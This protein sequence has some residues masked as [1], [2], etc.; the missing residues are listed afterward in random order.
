MSKRIVITGATGLIGKKLV[1]TLSKRENEIIIFTRNLNK[2]RSIFPRLETFVEWDYEKPELWQLYLE[3][4]DA[5][6]HLAGISLL[7]KR[8]NNHFKD[9]ALKSR[10]LSTKNLIEAI[11]LGKSQP[12][13]FI[14]ASAIGFYGNRKDELLTENS[15]AGNDFLANVCKVWETESEKVTD[16]G[17]RNVRVR[18]GIVLTPDDG[19]LKQML[20]P[21][22]LFIGGPLGNGNQWMSWLHIDDIINIYLYALDNKEIYGAINAVSP[23]PIRMKEFAKTLGKILKRPAIFP[24]PQCILRLVVGEAA[25]VVTASQ[26]V[27][28]N[29]LLRSGY[30][31]KFNYLSEAFDDLLN[32]KG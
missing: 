6:I 32:K 7:S 21:Y 28:S 3:N 23:N 2:A 31:F 16:L 24:V 25:E 1:N 30:K 5:I 20:F 18:T 29:K 8:W 13:V 14:S 9:E 27:D 12:E 26:K 10:E 17:I 15:S 11:R 4:V 22:K 19:A